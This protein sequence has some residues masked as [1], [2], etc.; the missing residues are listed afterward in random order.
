MLG[1]MAYAEMAGR[2]ASV[3]GRA[4]FDLVRD[5]LGAGVSLVNLLASYFITLLTL[6]AEIG[7]VALS[8]QL[9]SSVNYLLFVP[10]IAVLVWVVCWRV[11]FEV[12]D[13]LVGLL[14][15]ALVVVAV[16]VWGAHPDWGDFR[17]G[18]SLRLICSLKPSG[19]KE[20]GAHAG[21]GAA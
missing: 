16:A 20:L 8:L 10:V 13:N 2:V 21:Q 14:G 3:S 1:I 7:G 6:T 17:P 19:L 12:M 11:K 15:P 9:A 4:G 18:W 5:R